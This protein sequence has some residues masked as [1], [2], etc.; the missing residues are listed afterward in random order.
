L[1]GFIEFKGQ[2]LLNPLNPFNPWLEKF[3]LGK[4]STA[5]GRTS[6]LKWKDY[7]REIQLPEGVNTENATASFKNGVLEE[8]RWAVERSGWLLVLDQTTN[9]PR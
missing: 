9:H 6:W 4:A 3:S 5:H 7:H 2:E 1:N 8:D